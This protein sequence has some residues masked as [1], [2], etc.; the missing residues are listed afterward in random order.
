MLLIIP[1]PRTFDHPSEMIAI[2][3]A[4][5]MICLTFTWTLLNSVSSKWVDKACLVGEVYAGWRTFRDLFQYTLTVSI[6]GQH[7]SDYISPLSQKIFWFQEDHVVMVSDSSFSPR[8][9]VEDSLLSEVA[10]CER[11]GNFMHLA[12]WFFIF[13][14]FFTYYLAQYLQ[15]YTAFPSLAAAKCLTSDSAPGIFL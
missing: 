8:I 1:C 5:S 12:R 13:V 3:S 10:C 14:A 6:R 11:W 9:E 15:M 7:F 4:F 2:Q